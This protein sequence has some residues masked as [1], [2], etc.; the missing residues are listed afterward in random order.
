M[1]VFVIHSGAD[2]EDTNRIISASGSWRQRQNLKCTNGSLCCW[3]K[4]L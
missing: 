3:E 4:I 1:N 2:Y